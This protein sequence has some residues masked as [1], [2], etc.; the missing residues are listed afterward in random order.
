M[1]NY[2]YIDEQKDERQHTQSEEWMPGMGRIA[3]TIHVAV[4]MHEQW[5]KSLQL[6]CQP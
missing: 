5:V 6:K 4:Q 1:D 2:L 3:N